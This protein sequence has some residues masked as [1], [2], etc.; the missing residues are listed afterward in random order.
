MACR[1]FLLNTLR[2]RPYSDTN[3]VERTFDI[4]I[5]SGSSNYHLQLPRAHVTCH[6]SA[7]TTRGR[8][9]DNWSTLR[10]LL[11]TTRLPRLLAAPCLATP[12]DN[13]AVSP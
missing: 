9:Y 10:R 1:Y 8:N 3:D 6:A 7:N 5:Q 4:T 13:A 2:T 11:A 12:A